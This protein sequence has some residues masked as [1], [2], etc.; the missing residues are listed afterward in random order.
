MIH[1][2][3]LLCCTSRLSIYHQL[4]PYLHLKT[5]NVTLWQGGWLSSLMLLIILYWLIDWLIDW[6]F[7]YYLQIVGWAVLPC[8]RAHT[9][10]MRYNHT[11]HTH[12]YN[13]KVLQNTTRTTHII[14]Y[15]CLSLCEIY[16]DLV[17]W[18]EVWIKITVCHNSNSLVMR[19]FVKTNLHMRDVVSNS[20]GKCFHCGYKQALTGC[21]WLN[22]LVLHVFILLLIVFVL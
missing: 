6:L 22:S 12:T 4:W 3:L 8:Q 21:C 2:K 13:I 9:Y 11:H 1:W 14:L 7:V 20:W 19:K 5:S 16:C 17:R 10:N 15:W 18:V